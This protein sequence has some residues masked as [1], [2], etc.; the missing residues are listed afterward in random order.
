MTP[1]FPDALRALAAGLFLTGSALTAAPPTP[2]ATGHGIDLAAIDRSV[3]PG[4]GFYAYANGAWTK[5]TVIPADRGAF[6]VSDMVADRTNRRVAELIREAAKG[7]AKIGSDTQKVS[8]YYLSYLDEAGM[9]AKGLSP[10]QPS[11]EA[12]AKL[13]DATA[14]SAYLGGTLRAD[15]DVLNSTN[16]Y[17]PNFL[18][19]WVAQDLNNPNRYVPFLLQGGLGLPDRDYYLSPSPRMGDLRAKYQAHIAAML[20]LAQ[21]PDAEAKAA[22]IFELER[23]IAE[24]HWSREDTGDVLKG[25]NRW[26]RADFDAK[27]PG[28]D[29][30][31]FFQAAGLGK[32]EDFVV[33]QPSAIT[34]AAALVGSEPLETWKDYLRFRSIQKA[35]GVLPKAFRDE[36]FAFYGTA[37]SGIPQQRERWE[38]AVNATSGALG[39]VVGKMYVARFFP[40]SEKARAQAMVK[41]L[42]AAFAARIDKLEWMAPETKARA[43]AKLAVLKVGVGYPDTWTDY[44]GLKI[45]RGDALGNLIRAEEY[46]LKLNLQKLGRPVD[47]SEWVMTPQTVNAVNL[48]AMNSMNFPAA[49]LQP[50]DFDA[51]RTVAMNYGA[52]GAVI[53]HEISH[54]FDDQGA[55]FDETGRLNNWWTKEDFAHFE[56]SANQLVA[57]F[58]AYRPF[59]DAAVNGKQTLGENIADVAGLA[60]S[61]DAYRLALKGK[62]APKVQGL[63][64]DQQFFLSYAQSWRHKMREPVY[65]QRLITD[66]HAPADWRTETVRNID[67]WY[68]AFDVKPGQARYLEPKDRVRIW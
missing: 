48:P 65:R 37:L 12:I 64:G 6:G 62:P 66:G 44:S 17:T 22:R 23:R 2:S 8:D 26:T 28:L 59:P 11:L 27:A 16:L 49:I 9:D 41:N 32:Q 63:T 21:I 10:L 29:W 68:E 60:A 40:P 25:N 13:S 58:N 18:G 54:S 45:V 24:K 55:L 46:N 3:L 30:G 20:R 61:Y 15:V 47:R 50:P 39:E 31:A 42:I 38:R 43:K 1:S 4:N 5:A 36:A 56:A 52:I 67:A 34:G 7:K 57:Q 14:L 33:W 35:A 53:G 51:K 19:L